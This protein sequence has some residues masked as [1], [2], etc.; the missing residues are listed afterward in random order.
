M[1]SCMDESA[2]EVSAL[3]LKRDTICLSSRYFQPFV[4]WEKRSG[5]FPYAHLAMTDVRPGW[6]VDV[7]GLAVITT[8]NCRIS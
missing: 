8:V 5:L 3:V 2:G 1:Y 7:S 4:R 6:L